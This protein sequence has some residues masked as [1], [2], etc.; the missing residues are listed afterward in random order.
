MPSPKFVGKN[1]AVEFS[2]ADETAT[3]GSL[4]WTRLG[5]MRG[6]SLECTWDTVDATADTSAGNSK[7]MLATF[8][9]M[10]FSG[11]G[12]SYGETISGQKTLLSHFMNPGSGTQYQ[13]KA[14]FRLTEP[15]GTV[16]TG[17]FMITTFGKEHPY[18]DVGTWSLGATSNGACTYTPT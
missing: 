18:S 13:P 15:D 5:A 10:T 7:E 14:W 9:G 4:T 3:V 6:K 17:P 12:L 1:V 11:D 8:F 2:I 16:T